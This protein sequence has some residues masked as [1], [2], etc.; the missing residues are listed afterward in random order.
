M[1]LSRGKVVI[2][3]KIN[4]YTI[5]ENVFFFEPNKED[6]YDKNAKLRYIF[7]NTF[8][9]TEEEIAISEF[10]RYC[11][12]KSL[13]INKIFFENECLR[14][15]YSAQFDFAKALELI[16][17]NFEF[18]LSD[19]LPIKEKD[20]IHD[21]N[22][23]VMYWH[24]RDKK[25]RPIMIINLL[26]IELL[27]VEKLTNLFFFCFEFFLKYLCIPGKVENY[28]S[29]IDCSGISMSKF[30]MSTFMKLLEIM[31]SKYR[32]RLFRMYIIDAPKF[33]KTF[34]KSF[35]NFAPSYMT[36][37][38]KILDTNYV[39]YLREEILETQLERKYGGIQEIKN[40]IFYP[41]SFY[42]NC[43]HIK[44]EVEEEIGKNS[45]VKF[46]VFNEINK[47]VYEYVTSGYS[48]HLKLIE[49]SNKEE[50]K[51]QCSY[52]NEELNYSNKFK[53][54]SSS[55]NGLSK[56]KKKKKKLSGNDY[57]LN[58]NFIN[59]VM[60]EEYHVD[61][62]SFLKNNKYINSKCKYIVNA[63]SSHIWFFKIKHLY[64]PNITVSYLISRFPFLISHLIVKSNFNSMRCYFKYIE[65]NITVEALTHNTTA[66]SR[67]KNG[68]SN[69][70]DGRRS[71]GTSGNC[72]HSIAHTLN[73]SN[74]MPSVRNTEEDH[75]TLN[76]I[77]SLSSFNMSSNYEKESN[78]EKGKLR[79]TNK[80]KINNKKFENTVIQERC[81]IDDEKKKEIELDEE[82]AKTSE[83][84]FYKNSV[85]IFEDNSKN[86]LV[87]EGHILNNNYTY[88]N[89]E[90]NKQGKKSFYK[91]KAANS[92]FMEEFTEQYEKIEYAENAFLNKIGLDCNACNNAQQKF[93]NTG[94]A[95][96]CLGKTAMDFQKVY[97]N[98]ASSS[99][100]SSDS[101]SG[102][103]S[104][105]TDSRSRH[106]GSS[107]RHAG[108][109]SR[110]TGS[111]SRHTGSS[112]RHTGSSS[113]HTG[114]SS[115]HT[116]SNGKY[117]AYN[118]ALQNDN[119][120][121]K[122]SSKKPIISLKPIFPKRLDYDPSSYKKNSAT[123]TANNTNYSKSTNCA[124][125]TNYT[126]T[127]N[128][129][130]INDS[131]S[132]SSKVSKSPYKK[133]TTENKF[134]EDTLDDSTS[135]NQYYNKSNILCNLSQS[136]TNV[137]NTI[138]HELRNENKKK[139]VKLSQS[140]SD[141]NT[142]IKSNV[143]EE[144][145]KKLKKIKIIGLQFFNKTASKT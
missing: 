82:E 67:R 99:S 4:E 2:E 13:K 39:P 125:T 123:T 88:S 64:L 137:T 53:K 145:K 102:S 52:L 94:A 135:D 71:S 26:N 21:I 119:C 133:L 92:L 1:E 81:N 6:V 35:L 127:T 33:F 58:K 75:S 110:H 74:I 78:K 68:G 124:N 49:N 131:N 18:R 55:N 143:S 87:A 142:N 41:F 91:I 76:I 29:L 69:G 20:V 61:N 139:N 111:S 40:N 116:D 89:K 100:V 77:K 8:I 114:S 121:V 70:R 50:M 86:S 120:G 113:R 103:S 130:N 79:Y 22:K 11:K 97:K 83:I 141:I 104:S 108:S 109:S 136:D 101:P 36:K 38:L 122:L 42:P 10:K 105:H 51:K 117:S 24:G 47:K 54:S 95:E 46:D 19:V 30:P 60:K 59:S 34:G 85:S 138:D 56:K 65:N 93:E 37:K 72:H 48:M 9:N 63:G 115:R 43:Y 107:S 98:G 17:S 140:A 90:D 73:T 25:C 27:D 66:S 31:N 134:Q 5:D 128:G 144:G 106:T 80:L 126:Y 132:R 16:K 96:I 23:G 62:N 3:K 57:F 7:H 44:E 15:L 12:N 84:K 112:S 129:A 32:C 45:Y 28:I 14:Y 118:N